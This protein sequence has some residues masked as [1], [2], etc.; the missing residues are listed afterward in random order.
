MFCMS[1]DAGEWCEWCISI[2]SVHRQISNS[3]MLALQ[4]AESSVHIITF[5]RN[6]LKYLH[7][8]FNFHVWGRATSNRQH[9]WNN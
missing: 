8:P 4:V 9:I 5:A 3:Q 2:K 6:V 1:M 7:V